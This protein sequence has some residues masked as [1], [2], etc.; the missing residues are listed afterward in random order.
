VHSGGYLLATMLVAVIVYEK[1]G[2]GIL[3]RLWVNVD[4]VWS[5]ALVITGIVT[6]FV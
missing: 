4:L 6:P 1:V 5:A 3:R 2:V